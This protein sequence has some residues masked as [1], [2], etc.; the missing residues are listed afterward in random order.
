[1][2]RKL[3]TSN[4]GLF[5]RAL[6]RTGSGGGSNAALFGLS[7]KMRH[8]EIP[9]EQVEPNPDQPR[10]NARGADIAALAAS[11]G[12][13]GLLQPIN[14]REIAPDRFQ[15][16]AGERRYWAFRTLERETIPAL[17]IDTDDVQALA[18]IENAQRVDLH[19]IDLALTL[20]K[21]IGDK[22]LTQ[23]QAAVLIGKSQ[24]YVARLLG[25]LRLPARIL[26]EA[27]D[28]PA[29]SVSLL[30]ELAEL[31]DE[32]IQ[33]ALWARAGD[34]L[35]VKDVRNAKQE[36]KAATPSAAPA[37]RALRSNVDR[38]HSLRASGHALAEDQ[39]QEL[40]ELRDAIDAL[41]RE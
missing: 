34:G 18:L 15:I 40:R 22:G 28:R 26:E 3:D 24:E 38:I 7:G 35:T 12:E 39:R 4:A 13:R 41:L 16:V 11:I 37:L 27:P 1:M 31:P 29:V 9:L 36:R 23:E 17:V 5:K 25:I 30:M 10:R 6:S 20:A 19:P 32:A 2:A 33:L 21:L 8:R 14:V